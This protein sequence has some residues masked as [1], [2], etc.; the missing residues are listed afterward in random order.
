LQ[1]WWNWWFRNSYNKVQVSIMSEIKVN[2][3]SPRTNCGT[4]TLGDS[5]DTF[6]IPSGATITNA[7]T[8]SGFGA[9]GEISWDTTVKTTGTFTA[10]A[11]VGYFCN[12]SGGTITV[13][14]PA[15]AAG[16]SVALADYARTWDTSS[17]TVTP[18]GSDKIGGTNANATL[19]TEGQS[20]TFV[21]IDSTQGW[22]NVIDSTSN[23]TGQSFISATVSG[24]CN[25]LA[26]SPCGNYKLAT[27]K[28]P[29]TFCVASLSTSA[30]NNAVDYLIVAGG[31][32]GAGNKYHNTAGGGAGA[33]GV[34]A[35]ACTYTI[36]PA[37]AAPLVAS[38]ATAVTVTVQGYP[39][40]VGAGGAGGDAPNGSPP[41]NGSNGAN[42]TALG[43][44][45]TG[46]GYGGLAAPPQPG[47]G[48]EGGDG[49]SGGGKGGPGPWAGPGYGCGNSPSVTPPQGNPGGVAMSPCT[50]QGA[51]GG[52][53][54]LAVGTSGSSSGGGAGGVGAG[55]PTVAVGT[56][57][58]SSGGWYYFGGGGG[59]ST[60]E[61]NPSPNPGGAGGLGGGASGQKTPGASSYPITLGTA[62]TGGGAASPGASC[63]PT[64]FRT[65]GTG[66]SGIVIL[67]YKFQ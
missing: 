32:G 19:S 64:D 25:T 10:T 57:G 3:I 65:G 30:P 13:N 60:Y 23:I 31:G 50:N 33:G 61:P 51:A 29:G 59:G 37:P 15:G 53:G 35:S 58:E 26:T 6:T 28:N 45:S 20:V 55:F 46:G 62:N 7:G 11:G 22:I 9:T 1:H 42:S 49:G 34:R 8:A 2:K 56:A 12:T 44:T 36:G 18:N 38:P 16:S 67:R 63:S 48:S 43:L 54:A 39:I 47:C 27:F 66:G 4:V 21:Y 41:D 52:G 14:L 24:S 5:G 17:V 40:T